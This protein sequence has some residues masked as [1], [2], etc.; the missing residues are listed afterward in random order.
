MMVGAPVM[1]KAGT[2]HG[3]VNYALGGTGNDSAKFMI[4]QTTG[5]ITTAVDLDYEAGAG[6]R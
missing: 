2:N 4:D 1:V 3:M 6:D 5:Q